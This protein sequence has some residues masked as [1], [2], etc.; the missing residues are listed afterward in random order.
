VTGELGSSLRSFLKY[1]LI[2]VDIVE[3]PSMNTM[4][5]PRLTAR[6]E[7]ERGWTKNGRAN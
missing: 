2:C 6:P 1:Q 5:D 4:T 3:M 7:P